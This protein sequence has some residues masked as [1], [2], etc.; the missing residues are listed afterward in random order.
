VRILKDLG[1]DK[2]GT[3]TRQ[4]TPRALPHDSI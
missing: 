4:S 1:Q 2:L 3:A